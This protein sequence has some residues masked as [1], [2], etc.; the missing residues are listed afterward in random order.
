[1]KGRK[2]TALAIL[3]AG[4]AVSIWL[5]VGSRGKIE[6]KEPFI[7][8][9]GNA[10]KLSANLLF[11][12]NLKT[13]P[14]SIPE[15]SVKTAEPNNLTDLLVQ[16]YMQEIVKRNPT[17]PQRGESL[18]FPSASTFQN[19]I[20][21]KMAQ[22]LSYRLYDLKDIRISENT[23]PEK[24]I[25]YIE[26]LY[27]ILKKYAVVFG[28]DITIALEDFFKNR[29]NEKLNRIA[30]NIPP[31]INELLALSPPKNFAA[32]HLSL[33]NLWQKKLTIYEAIL[34]TATDPLKAYLAVNQLVPTLQE[35]FDLQMILAKSYQELKS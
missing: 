14:E 13:K 29:N 8:F 17:A 6:N 15:K 5:V 33:L 32:T 7:I 1:M 28:T 21:E 18:A 30:E 20:Q 31:L 19:I 27:E 10:K 16:N 9:E 22:G 4:A 34:N 11:P 12:P 2:I 24:Q 23:N 35:D 3:V 26:N 25:K